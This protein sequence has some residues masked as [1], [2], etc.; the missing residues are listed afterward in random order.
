M[1]TNMKTTNG[2]FTCRIDA[3][4]AGKIIYRI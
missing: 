4:S 2:G 3:V 1:K